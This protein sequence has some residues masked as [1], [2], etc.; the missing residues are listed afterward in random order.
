MTRIFLVL[1]I[2][3]IT[4]STFGMS[5]EK[6]R[7]QFSDEQFQVLSKS[8]HYGLAYNMENTLTALAWTE[9][10][11][12]RFLGSGDPSYGVYQA[13]I[14]TVVNRLKLKHDPIVHN[15]LKVELKHN[16]AFYTAHA[17]TEV[18]YWKERRDIWWNTWA[19][20]NGGYRYEHYYPQQ[21]AK[22]IYERIKIIN[23]C[24]HL[25]VM[26]PTLSLNS[27]TF[28]L[29]AKYTGKLPNYSNLE[30]FIDKHYFIGFVY[31]PII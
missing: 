27:T 25:F 22:K 31:N 1:L 16:E 5:C 13:Y 2:T 19:S 6:F 29:V 14:P 3:L 11:A 20:Y 23:K 4:D 12:G 9:S 21:Y 26:A 28:I 7:S 24:S 17:I 8:Y 10:S 30:R 15:L 18:L